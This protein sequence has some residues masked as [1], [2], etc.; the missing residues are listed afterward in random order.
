[1]ADLIAGL[2]IA[3]DDAVVQ[4]YGFWVSEDHPDPDPAPEAKI[5]AASGADLVIAKSFGTL[6]TMVACRTHGFAPKACVFIGTP[7]RRSPEIAIRL[8]Q[9][10]AAMPTLLIQQTEDFNGAFAEVAAVAARAPSTTALE[11]EGDDHLYINLDTICPLIDAW[12]ANRSSIV[13]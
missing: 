13:S 2:R 12:W 7:M 10:L 4:A 3:Q 6:V 8:V 1:M 5:A 9:H 11:I